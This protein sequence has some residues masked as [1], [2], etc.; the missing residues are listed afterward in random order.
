MN[1]ASLYEWVKENRKRDLTIHEAKSQEKEL[2][3]HAI[4]QRPKKRISYI[5]S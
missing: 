5:I 2:N 1:E 4:A 3:K